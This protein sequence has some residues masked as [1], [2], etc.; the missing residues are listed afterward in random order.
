MDGGWMN[1][2]IDG[3]MDEWIDVGV[4]GLMEGWMD[5]GF[6]ISRED[7]SEE[8]CIHRLTEWVDEWTDR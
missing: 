6:R 5:R 7:G 1:G 3:W 2:W 8:G 4:C